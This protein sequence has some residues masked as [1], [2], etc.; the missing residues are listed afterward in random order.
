MLCC[1]RVSPHASV[2][3]LTALHTSLAVKAWLLLGAS[4]P[5]HLPLA[6]RAAAC[7]AIIAQ[8]SLP[9]RAIGQQA[10]PETPNGQHVST[11]SPTGPL[12]C[13]QGSEVTTEHWL[14]LGS[15]PGWVQAAAW[16]C[17]PCCMTLS[18]CTASSGWYRALASSHQSSP[19]LGAARRRTSCSWR[20]GAPMCTNAAR[21]GGWMSAG[22]LTLAVNP[23]TCVRKA[24]CGQAQLLLAHLPSTAES[25][26]RS[27]VCVSTEHSA[28]PKVPHA[29]ITQQAS[30]QTE[31][32]S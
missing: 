32:G 30:T 7:V 21:C 15:S 25:D 18:S 19:T 5:V 3:T 10:R 29:R 22:P 20:G 24:Y 6:E 2:G 27:P 8:G 12:A 28:L 17:S 11:V 4:A 31:E 9:V 1:P 23:G 13:W 16:R 26:I 14:P